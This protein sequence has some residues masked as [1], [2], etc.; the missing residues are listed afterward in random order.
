MAFE[1]LSDSIEELNRHLKAYADSNAEYYKLK[2][3]KQATKGLTA[4][5][6]G[7]LMG[8]F[9]LFALIILSVAVAIAISNALDVPSAGYFIVGG[10]YVLLFIL[11]LLFGKKPLQKFLLV[12]LSRKIFNK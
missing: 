6:L 9:L 7:V 3:F 2:I 8:L 1:K 12:K 11:V 4:V 5:I 10:F